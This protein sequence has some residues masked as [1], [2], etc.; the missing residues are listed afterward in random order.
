ML[1]RNRPNT[2]LSKRSKGKWNLTHRPYGEVVV[3]LLV[4]WVETQSGDCWKTSLLWKLQARCHRTSPHRQY[5]YWPLENTPKNAG[6]GK[7]YR[8]FC[9]YTESYTELVI[10]CEVAVWIQKKNPQSCI[11]NELLL[12]EHLTN[13]I[14]LCG[15]L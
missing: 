1:N 7:L 11:W 10:L 9:C 6:K 13:L 5:W 14:S 4:Q 15:V 12:I 2:D 8:P 3:C